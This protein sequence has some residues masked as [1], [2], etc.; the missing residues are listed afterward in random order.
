MEIHG[1][2]VIGIEGKVKGIRS[3]SRTL[4]SEGTQTERGTH[5][6]ELDID[7]FVVA[8]VEVNGFTAVLV[9]AKFRELHRGRGEFSGLLDSERH[10][11]G[12]YI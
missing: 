2:F 8:G 4:I 3:A 1:L 10:G 11:S 9:L 6:R 12:L 5:E 7:F